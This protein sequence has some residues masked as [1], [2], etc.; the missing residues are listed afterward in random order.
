VE[1]TDPR[2]AAD[3]EVK[4]KDF[5]VSDRVS[6]ELTA[7]EALVLFDWLASK[8]T[9]D[10]VLPPFNAEVRSVLWNIESILESVLVEPLARNYADLLEAAR[11]RLIPEGGWPD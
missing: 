6:I 8:K 4:A 5:R 1:S 9:L 3:Y 10:K 7:D 2:H 11:V